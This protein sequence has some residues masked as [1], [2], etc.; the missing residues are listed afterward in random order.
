MTAF[1]A[2]TPKIAILAL[3]LRLC[4]H[5]FYDLIAAWQQIILVCALLSLFVGT[6]G[7]INQNKIKRLFAYSSIA[8]VGYLLIGLGTGTI[9][10]TESLLVYIIIYILMIINIFGIIPVLASEDR[11][12]FT[13]PTHARSIPNDGTNQGS[14]NA[15]GTNLPQ[16]GMLRGGKIYKSFRMSEPSLCEAKLFRGGNPL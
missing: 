13:L 16:S 3:L 8:H 14:R 4:P 9:A 15:I 12:H 10:A 2:I 11:D 5:S 1:F 7:A 6:W